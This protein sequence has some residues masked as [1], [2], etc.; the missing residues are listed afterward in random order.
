MVLLMCSVLMRKLGTTAAV[1]GLVLAASVS[2]ACDKKDSSGDQR[3]KRRPAK[4]KAKAP[5][6]KKTVV[7]KAV[8]KPP[9]PTAPAE[10]K[11]AAD[12]NGYEIKLH[13]P[14][15]PGFRYRF[16]SAGTTSVKVTASTQQAANKGTIP[17]TYEAEVT[18]RAVNAKGEP[19]VEE[20]KVIK[21]ITTDAKGVRSTPLAPGTKVVA[22]SK[23]I[24]PVFKLNGAPA[25]K[26]ITGTLGDIIRVSKGGATDDQV[27]GVRGKKKIGE[28]WRVNARALA[29][30]IG[31]R[32]ASL[33]ARSRNI[34]GKATLLRVADVFGVKSLVVRVKIRVKNWAEKIGT[35]KATAG[36]ANWTIEKSV[37]VDPTSTQLTNYKERTRLFIEGTNVNGR[38]TLDLEVDRTES[39]TAIE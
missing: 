22:R 16:R 28:S 21:L 15:K 1:A 3:A 36:G 37:P 14:V 4:A 35:L 18:V 23:G 13:R 26:E 9:T 17:W 29:K 24:N 6:I 34:N 12:P 8:A 7:A 19:T 27:F 25:S 31:R 30:D 38:V 39:R 5:P 32:P 20:H 11:Y 10:K 33:P 2:A